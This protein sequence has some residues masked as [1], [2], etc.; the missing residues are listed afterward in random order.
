[1]PYENLDLHDSAHGTLPQETDVV[2]ETV[3]RRRRGCTYPQVNQLFSKL[4]RIL[5]I[6][7]YCTGARLNAPA[8]AAAD[9]IL[10]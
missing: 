9:S 4:L 6:A 5:G 2:Y 1:M 8:G 10:R 3:V 7:S